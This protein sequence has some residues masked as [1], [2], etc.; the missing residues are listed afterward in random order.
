M[1][2]KITIY[3]PGYILFLILFFACTNKTIT[4]KILDAA[5]N[6]Q[7]MEISS[8]KNGDAYVLKTWFTGDAYKVIMYHDYSGKMQ[9]YESYYVTDEKFSKAK[10]SWKNDT[11]LSVT[12]FNFGSDKKT[13]FDF[14]GNGPCSGLK[15]DN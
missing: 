7:S 11:T 13:H 2:T 1:K 3:K 6:N 12:L 15:T 8:H 4:V 5:E 9:Q 10:L 14:F